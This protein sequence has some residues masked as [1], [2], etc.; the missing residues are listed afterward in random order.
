MTEPERKLPHTATYCGKD[1]AVA[2]S[3]NVV[4][5]TEA[6]SKFLR[7]PVKARL[8]DE[9]EASAFE[10]EMKSFRTSKMN[11]NFLEDFF[12][13]TESSKP[14]EVGE[15]LAECLLEND[16]E[17]NVAWPWNNVR[18]R[19][20][21]KASLPGADLVG[22]IKEDERAFL[23]FGEVKTS[24]DINSPPGVMYG[25][26]GMTWQLHDEATRF[27]VQHSLLRWL[28]TRCTTTELKQ[29]Y[30]K[31]IKEFVQSNGK[32]IVLVGMLLRD[33]SPNENDVK[34]RAEA[35]SAKISHPTSAEV[36]AWYLPV[37]IDEWPKIA[38]GG[39]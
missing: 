15:A 27:D 8:V 26:S 13:T 37:Q 5:E 25:S 11:D 9:E 19:K 36:N 1:G 18:D 12:K 38:G 14:W 22:F 6:F 29:L 20:T 28:R 16:V 23:L 39:Q 21:P 35:L 4:S 2:W 10:A 33:T 30:R 3:G 17:K 24:S 31:A 34:G 7:G 32:S